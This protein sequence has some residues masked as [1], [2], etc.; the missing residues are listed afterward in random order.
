MLCPTHASCSH[1]LWCNSPIN[2]RFLLSPSR[3]STA[4]L[5]RRCHLHRRHVPAEA[6]RYRHEALLFLRCCVVH[7]GAQHDVDAPV[8]G[9]TMVVR[10]Q[11]P[12]PA[13]YRTTCPAAHK[14]GE[15]SGR[16]LSHP[17]GAAM[18]Q[19]TCGRTMSRCRKRRA[20]SSPNEL[21]RSFCM[22]RF[23]ACSPGCTL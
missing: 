11:R 9:Q 22:K 16:S 17:A 4:R 19:R 6:S 20:G 10:S 15:S 7:D 1:S 14:T 18:R 2:S 21:T 3:E 13:Q 5:A 23:T 8:T 12:P